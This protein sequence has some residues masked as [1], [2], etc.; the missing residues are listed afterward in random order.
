MAQ[1]AVE[2][3]AIDIALDAVH[4][5]AIRMLPECP[6]AGVLQLVNIIMGYPEGIFVENGVVEVID[7]ELVAGIED[8]LD[9]VFRL[10]HIEP[11]LDGLLQLFLGETA[12]LFNIQDGWQVALFEMYLMQIETGL[13]FRVLIGDEEMISTSDKVIFTCVEEV[14]V[15]VLVEQRDALGGLDD[16]ESDGVVVQVG[17]AHQRPIDLLLIVADVYTSYII[18]VGIGGFL[19]NGSPTKTERIDEQIIEQKNVQGSDKAYAQ[20]I[21][22][23]GVFAEPTGPAPYSL[24]TFLLVVLLARHIEN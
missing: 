12:Y 5:S 1:R 7:T 2:D 8:G 14:I 19:E 16:N 22:P 11:F 9:A 4:I 3:V 21:A 15:E 23:G 6:L 13:P 24:A 17:I 20:E 10:H 18:A